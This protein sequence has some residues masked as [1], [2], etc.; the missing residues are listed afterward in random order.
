MYAANPYSTAFLLFSFAIGLWCSCTAKTKKYQFLI[1]QISFVVLAMIQFPYKGVGYSEQNFIVVGCFFATY[2]FLSIVFFAGRMLLGKGYISTG[3]FLY[4]L[5]ICSA[6]VI[7][8][9]FFTEGIYITTENLLIAA[10]ISSTAS[11]IISIIYSRQARGLF[12][13]FFVAYSPIYYYSYTSGDLNSL[14]DFGEI[15][16]TCIIISVLVLGFVCKLFTP[17][18]QISDRERER[19]ERYDDKQ[20]DKKLRQEELNRREVSRQ[21]IRKSNGQNPYD[22]SNDHNIDFGLKDKSYD[23]YY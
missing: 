4:S 18:D 15:T 3:S 2:S 12:L 1:L 16:M 19:I 5:P 22:D 20:R 11:S 14:E 9:W 10:Y 23:N 21:S 13:L 6:I 8:G 17:R 7:I